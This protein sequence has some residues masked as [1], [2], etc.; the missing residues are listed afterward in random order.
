MYFRQRAKVIPR[1]VFEVDRPLEQTK[2]DLQEFRALYNEATAPR[3]VVKRQSRGCSE[4]VNAFD[5]L[6]W[7]SLLAIF[8]GVVSMSFSGITR[9]SCPC[10][11]STVVFALGFLLLATEFPLWFSWCSHPARFRCLLAHSWLSS[12]LLRALQYVVTVVALA[13][14]EAIAERAGEADQYGSFSLINMGVCCVVSA[15]VH[16]YQLAVLVLLSAENQESRREALEVAAA[17]REAQTEA[18]LHVNRLAA[19]KFVQRYHS[20]V[21]KYLFTPRQVRGLVAPSVA[22]KWSHSSINLRVP[23]VCRYLAIPFSIPP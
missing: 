23:I 3:V 19:A 11:R 20:Q 15:S 7:T 12:D 1:T 2:R 18:G 13:A 6:R 22:R 5:A 21:G 4:A 17:V 14:T 16:L 8:N 10:T 9:S